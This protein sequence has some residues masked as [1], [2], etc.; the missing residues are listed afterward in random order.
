[1]GAAQR[2]RKV[3]RWCTEQHSS[4]L[5]PANE[6]KRVGRRNVLTYLERNQIRTANRQRTCF[7]IRPCYNL[8]NQVTQYYIIAIV[9]ALNVERAADRDWPLT[10]PPGKTR[11]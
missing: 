8:V 9:A 10:P 11:R 3:N 6:N 2:Q 7:D 4:K 5:P 1:M